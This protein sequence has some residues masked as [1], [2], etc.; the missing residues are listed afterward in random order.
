ML[1]EVPD[2]SRFINE[3]K[4]LLNKDGKILISE[5]KFHVNKDD[6]EKS[7]E[8]IKDS[9]FEIIEEPN[10]FFQ[11]FNFNKSCL[12]GNF[13]VNKFIINNYLINLFS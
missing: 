3:L 6:F 9:G 8:L 5:P 4:N 10:I 2:Q 7:L 12:I 1:H 13:L 11:P